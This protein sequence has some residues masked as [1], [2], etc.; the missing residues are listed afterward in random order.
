MFNNTRFNCQEK[1][2]HLKPERYMKTCQKLGF[3]LVAC[4]QAKVMKDEQ[5]RPHDLK[6]VRLSRGDI[7]SSVRES[8][9]YFHFLIR[10]CLFNCSILQL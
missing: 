9:K 2:I 6:Y 3:T 10:T 8:P 7:L 5:L 4:E 1:K